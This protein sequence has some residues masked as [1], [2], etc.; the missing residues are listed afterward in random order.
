[1]TGMGEDSN[2]HDADRPDTGR[3]R[4]PAQDPIAEEFDDM[5]E[6]DRHRKSGVHPAGV[7]GSQGLDEPAEPRRP[8]TPEG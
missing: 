6:R 4:G 7:P 2:G 8:G 3:H 1:M 5:V